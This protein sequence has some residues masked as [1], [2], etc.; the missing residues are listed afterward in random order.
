MSVGSSCKGDVV[1][2]VASALVAVEIPL[3][4]VGLFFPLVVLRGAIFGPFSVRPS[5]GTTC[6]HLENPSKNSH[7]QGVRGE[8]Q[9]HF[10]QGLPADNSDVSSEDVPARLALT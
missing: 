1:D 10:V 5:I 4:G 8:A 3:L 6:K 2:R 7:R 9:Q